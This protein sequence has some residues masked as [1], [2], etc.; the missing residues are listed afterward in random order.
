MS[1]EANAGE[2]RTPIMVFNRTKTNDADGY[3]TETWTNVFGQDDDGNEKTVR[4]KWINVHGTEIYDAAQLGLTEPATLTIRYSPLI[5]AT[6]LIYRAAEYVEALAAGDEIEDE[7]ESAA[8][9]NAA[10]AATAYEIISLDN[11]EQRNKWLEIKLKRKVT[12]V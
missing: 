6:C 9:V 8:A 2:L 7:G 12:P 4:C 1:K 3:E 5:T 10:L 11:V